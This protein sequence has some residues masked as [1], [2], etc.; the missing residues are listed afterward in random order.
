MLE[1]WQVENA[2]HKLILFYNDREEII[3]A[4]I[5][6]SRNNSIKISFIRNLMNK[7]N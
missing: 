7:L 2:R 1:N 3:T 5:D 4:R 6:K